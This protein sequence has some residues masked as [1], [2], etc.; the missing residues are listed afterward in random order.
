MMYN[1]YAGLGA[2][3]VVLIIS[4]L[5]IANLWKMLMPW[6]ESIQ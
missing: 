5:L 1:I 6:Q 3:L 4:A 2:V